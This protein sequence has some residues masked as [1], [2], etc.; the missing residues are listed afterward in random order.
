MNQCYPYS[1]HNTG[2]YCQEIA[3]S[4]TEKGL[5]QKNQQFG[6]YSTPLK[7]SNICLLFT[8][9]ST[10]LDTQCL[11]CVVMNFVTSSKNAECLNFP[12]M[13]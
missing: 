5:P 9:H 3:K 4:S 11:K 6:L 10:L 12:A 8:L 7:S 2:C 13:S 1:T